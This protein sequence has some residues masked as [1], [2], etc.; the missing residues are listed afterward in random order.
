MMHS[1]DQALALLR[2][3]AI[4]TQLAIMA[5]C[6]ALV[7]LAGVALGSAHTLPATLIAAATLLVPL[8]ARRAG[9][10]EPELRLLLGPAIVTYPALFTLLFADHPWQIDMHMSFFVALST[11]VLLCDWRP[12][13]AASV[14]TA[15]HHLLLQ[16]SFSAWVF[17]GVGSLAR[18][19]LHGGL[20]ALEALVL[21]QFCELIA[22]LTRDHAAAVRATEEARTDA[23]AAQGE[24]ERL[25]SA[26]EGALR[27]TRAAQDAA[28]RDRAA[29]QAMEAKQ[30]QALNQRRAEIADAIEAGIGSLTAELGATAA[31]LASQGSQLA[32]SAA[33]LSE[34][35]E[36][37]SRASG[38]AVRNIGSVAASAAELTSS[39]RRVD[40]RAREAE[41]VAR[42]TAGTV[43]RLPEGLHGLAGEI[44]AA[45]T[46]LEHVGRIAAQSNLLALNATIEA[47][48]GAGAGTGFAVV[49]KEMKAMASE[50]GHTAADIAERLE[51][52][53]TAAG[54][55]AGAIATAREHAGEITGTASGIAREVQDQRLATEAIAS[56]A[57][58]VMADAEATDAHSQS[59]ESAA[60]ENEAIAARTIAIADILRDRSAT[61]AVRFDALIAG[62]RAA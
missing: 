30:E 5:M 57:A 32:H 2:R 6:T 12:I 40:E 48:R 38:A 29:R 3:T 4:A 37:L 25:R 36:T 23:V 50:T 60:G 59:I 34:G 41:A 62:L 19:L 58:R 45:R 9:W 28:D 33:T 44:A 18:V 26:A 31:E 22:R 20:V 24:A 61:L 52:I 51:R 47:A 35:A 8:A 43:E 21:I 27:D 14:L 39:I 15:L 1:D 53:G 13:V 54:D 49:A 42:T 16:L 17:P 46:T 11:L 56:A 10:P 7:P 55:F